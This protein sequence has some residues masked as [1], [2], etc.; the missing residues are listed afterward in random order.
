M[1]WVGVIVGEFIA[2]KAGI[3]YLIVY[4]GQVFKLNVVMMGVFVLAIFTLIMYQGV[5]LLE[6]YLRKKQSAKK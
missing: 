4:G 5:N 1:T 3:G 2:S 6:I